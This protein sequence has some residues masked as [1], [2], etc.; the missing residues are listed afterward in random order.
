MTLEPIQQLFGEAR[1]SSREPEI[2]VHREAIYAPFSRDVFFDRYAGWGLYEPD[3]ALIETAAYRR[4]PALALIGQSETTQIAPADDARLDED[5]VYFGPLIPHYG[6]FVVS[7]LARAWFVADPDMRRGRRVLCH[8]DHSPDRHFATSFM[9]PLVRSIGI[10]DAEFISPEEPMRLANVTVPAPAFVEQKEALKAFIGP[11][12]AM[13]DTLLDQASAR[14]T[15]KVAYLSKS[16]VDPGAVVHI[17]NEAALEDKLRDYGI[18]IFHPEQMSF[19]EQVRLF[20]DYETIVGFVGSAFHSHAFV[21]NPPKIIGIALDPYVN[22]NIAMVDALNDA[23]AQYFYPKGNLSE[24]AT[25]GY[26][27]SRSIRDPASLVVDLLEVAGVAKGRPAPVTL[28][29]PARDRTHGGNGMSLFSYFLG[30]TGRPIHKSGHYFFAYERHFGRYVG[31]PCTF[32]EIGAGNGGSSQMWKQW[33]GPLARIVTIDINPVCRQYGD[34]QV[35]VRIGSQSDTA[36]L[37]SL[38][39][40]F[41]VFD[42]VLDD[43][44]HHMRDVSASFAYLYDRIAANGVY[45][46]EDMHTA[47]WENYGGGKGLG[48]SMI[49][50]FKDHLDKLHAEHVRDGSLAPDK[51]T[52]Q[53]LAMT[54]YDSILVFEKTPYQNKIMRIVGDENLRVNY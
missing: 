27:I 18:D 2:T 46:I 6:H 17:T 8:S 31:Q 49:E 13:G 45:F 42:M 7:S 14:K 22:S 50:I 12:H 9:G 25:Q 3:G 35:E 5:V 38:I 43:G 34:E 28:L 40:E 23:S 20:S 1:I 48:S 19:A 53:T 24:N 30:N 52:R 11:L 41:G 54:A 10:S 37:A 33:L 29:E 44:S 21:R 4:G 32:L 47:Y 36:F 39:E 16:R 51:F 15:R 26:G